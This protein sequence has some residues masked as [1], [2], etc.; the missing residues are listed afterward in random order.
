MEK[1]KETESNTCRM[2]TNTLA[3]FQKIKSTELAFTTMLLIKL[4]DKESGKMES[5]L[6]GSVS[7]NQ[8]ILEEPKLLEWQA[9]KAQA[10]S[11]RGEDGKTIS[12]IN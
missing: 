5:E 3:N 9:V 7:L 12:K 10:D 4:R 2:V 11:G 6:P 8:L 1:P